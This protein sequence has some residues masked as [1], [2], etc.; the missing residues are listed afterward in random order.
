MRWFYMSVWPRERLPTP[1]SVQHPL[2]ACLFNLSVHALHTVSTTPNKP[3]RLIHFGQSYEMNH[4]L[5]RRLLVERDSIQ[6]SKQT[7]QTEAPVPGIPANYHTHLMTWTF[8]ESSPCIIRLVP[9]LRFLPNFWRW[10]QGV[11]QFCDSFGLLLL[12]LGLNIYAKRR[13]LEC[14]VLAYSTHP[15]VS[16]TLSETVSGRLRSHVTTTRRSVFIL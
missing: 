4:F 1:Y 3:F 11:S 9:S 14:K 2:N 6:C 8:H 13:S 5:E 16:S 12:L 15:G 10:M 7:N